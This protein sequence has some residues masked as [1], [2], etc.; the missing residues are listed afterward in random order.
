MA[1]VML[2]AWSAASLAQTGEAPSGEMVL[3]PP[4]VYTPLYKSEGD[5]GKVE[6]AA[7]Y[8]D[9][10]PV[11]NAEF[12][13]FVTANPK[14]RRSEVKRIFADESYLQHWGGDLDLGEH[15]ERIAQGPV[16]NVSWF[17]ARAYARWQGKRLPTQ[18][19]WEYAAGASE[20]RPYGAEE[21]GFNDRILAWYGKPTP[22]ILPAVG[23]L[24]PNYFGIHDLHG[25]VW[26]WVDDFNSALITGESR[27]DTGLER[28]LYCGSGSVGSFDV[29]NYAAFM[30][31]AFRSSLDARYAVANLGFR[32]A[33]DVELP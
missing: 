4:G 27:A 29:S 10:L 22:D 15:A 16:T 17:A 19:E 5:A 7:F 13:A 24:A 18:A 28:K 21:P 23:Q 20:D 32:C 9:P 3:I 30:R 8:L 1:L 2:L 33:K 31:Y 6:V 12:L 25:L 14:W 26:E 11:T